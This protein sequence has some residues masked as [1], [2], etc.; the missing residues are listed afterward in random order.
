MNPRNMAIAAVMHHDCKVFGWDRTAA[1][2]A[3]S[4]TEHY[5][6]A[7]DWNLTARHIARIAREKGWS[8]YIRRSETPHPEGVSTTA[9]MDSELSSLAGDRTFDVLEFGDEAA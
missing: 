1:Q 8:G 7:R 6:A 4:L 2:I 3:E 5:P 9:R